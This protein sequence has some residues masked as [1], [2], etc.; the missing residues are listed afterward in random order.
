MRIVP[1]MRSQVGAC[2]EIVKTSEPWKSL[3]EGIDFSRFIS[4][5]QA[6]VCV[7]G[8]ETAGFVIFTPDPVFARGG[9]LRAI[10]V[11]LHMREQGIGKKLMAFAEKETARQARNFYLCVSSFNR[12][13]QAFYNSL[14]YT[15]VGK[16]PGLI[17]PGTSEYI[18][19]KPLS[20]GVSPGNRKPRS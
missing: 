6:Y 11:S 9:Y 4:L 13:A 8:A 18:Y 16:I 5:K 10:G 19:W 15:R 17:T 14:G 20:A 12:Q 3:Q 2:T 1:M 7:A